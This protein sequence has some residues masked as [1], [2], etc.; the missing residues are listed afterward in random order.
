[1]PLLLHITH[2]NISICLLAK[3]FFSFKRMRCREQN[4]VFCTINII[5]VIIRQLYQVWM[6]CKNLF[7][8][9]NMMFC[10]APVSFSRF[11][12]PSLGFFFI[13]SILFQILFFVIFSK[14][15]SRIFNRV[16]RIRSFQILACLPLWTVLVI[17]Q[18]ILIIGNFSRF[19]IWFYN[20]DCCN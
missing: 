17:T 7:S 12:I 18:S 6:C 5:S 11:C 9:N 3:S 10:S 1:M 15:S 2:C 8:G 19:L 14:C 13:S 20:S 16:S 4:T